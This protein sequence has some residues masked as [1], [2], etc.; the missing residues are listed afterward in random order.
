MINCKFGRRK[1]FDLNLNELNNYY[2][3]QFIKTQHI[4]C[5]LRVI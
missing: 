4:Y 2:F 1:F 3:K 5:Y